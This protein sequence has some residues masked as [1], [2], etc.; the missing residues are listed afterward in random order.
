MRIGPGATPA[1]AGVFIALATIALLSACSSGAP[2]ASSADPRGEGTRRMAERLEQLARAT[3]VQESSWLNLERAE[4]LK[5]VLENATT[6]RE[7]F[8]LQPDY[9]DE[10]LKAGKTQEAIRAF[11]DLQ[12][13]ASAGTEPPS[14]RNRLFMRHNLA[15]A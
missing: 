2:G 4:R 1:P 15:I 7:Y 6:P 12:K 3:D 10:L 8:D 13:F 5:A 9:A 11:L 14:P